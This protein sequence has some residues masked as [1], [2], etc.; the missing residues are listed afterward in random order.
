MLPCVQENSTEISN[1]ALVRTNCDCGHSMAVD[2]KHAGKRI[3]CPECRGAVQV[4]ARPRPAKQ[5]AA[6][7]RSKQPQTRRAERTASKPPRRRPASKRTRRRAKQ[8]L[9]V[10]PWLVGAVLGLAGL[11]GVYYFFGGGSQAPADVAV[12][13][14][15]STQKDADAA[16]VPA[17]VARAD[18]VER[19]TFATPPVDKPSPAEKPASDLRA[20]TRN[21]PA[22]FRA[23]IESDVDISY[24]NPIGS[25]FLRKDNKW[26]RLY[27]ASGL[28]DPNERLSRIKSRLGS[29]I[30]NRLGTAVERKIPVTEIEK[31]STDVPVQVNLVRADSQG[32]ELYCPTAQKLFTIAP[33]GTVRGKTFLAPETRIHRG[34]IQ[35]RGTTLSRSSS[36]SATYD[37]SYET[38]SVPWIGELPQPWTTFDRE[39]EPEN[40]KELIAQAEKSVVR[41]DIVTPDGAGNGSGFLINGSGLIATNYHVIENAVEVAVFYK[42]GERFPAV[43]FEYLDAK[44]DLAIIR[45]HMPLGYFPGLPLASSAPEKGEE[46]IAFGAPL[47]LSFSATEGIVS[48]LRSGKDFDREGTWIQTTAAISPGNSGGPLVTRLGKVVGL[49]TMTLVG[50]QALNFAIGAD[51]IAEATLLD[52][53]V[54]ITPA[55]VPRRISKEAAPAEKYGDVTILDLEGRPEAEKLMAEMP[56]VRIEISV[57]AEANIKGAIEEICMT[58]AQAALAESNVK[59]VIDE[60]PVLFIIARVTGTQMSIAGHLYTGSPNQKGEGITINRLWRNAK[61]LGLLKVNMVKNRKLTGSPKTSMKRFYQGLQK[62]FLL[63]QASKKP[64]E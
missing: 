51:S 39:A 8:G 50:G 46:V 38:D 64:A 42:N 37:W 11:G 35:S 33:A 54:A 55:S 49:N 22:S 56:E 27:R 61:S 29:R 47:G 3:R 21:Q 63:S 18:R 7:T 25:G 43:G 1:M 30:G 15:N 23:A 6:P 14:P 17:S 10:P 60:G 4:P 62:A 34:G 58:T 41:I 52:K 45:A 24:V 5:K 36:T 53:P 20:Q 2:S 16:E 26:Y 32:I 28:P 13:E 9:S 31:P 57:T 19:P 59:V 44:R 48:A 40:L 12:T